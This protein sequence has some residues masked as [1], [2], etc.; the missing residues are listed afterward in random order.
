MCLFDTSGNINDDDHLV[1]VCRTIFHSFHLVY[2]SML[3]KLSII[4]QAIVYSFCCLNMFH[5]YV[6]LGVMH[7]YI[8]KVFNVGTSIGKV[9]FLG[10]INQ[11]LWC[12]THIETLRYVW[13]I[14]A[15]LQSRI[16]SAWQKQ[17]PCT[18][19]QYFLDSC[20]ALSFIM[21]VHILTFWLLCNLLLLSVWDWNEAR[22]VANFEGARTLAS[23]SWTLDHVCEIYRYC[24]MLI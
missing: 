24:G 6:F 5:L 20:D 17:D 16:I 12:L 22:N 21:P 1:S 8:K 2:M 7:C 14:S 15:L 19:L 9:G 13:A 11:K 4:N 10:E 23:D 18:V 3:T